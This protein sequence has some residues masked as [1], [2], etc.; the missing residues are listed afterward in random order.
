MIR[1]KAI[2]E[3]DIIKNIKGIQT[4]EQARLDGI[5]VEDKE[6]VTLCYSFGS[7]P[8]PG[9]DIK[10]FTNGKDKIACLKKDLLAAKHSIN[11][12][13]YIF[14]DDKIGKEVMSILC[15]K[16]SEGVDVRLIYDSIGSRHAP[17]RF[18]NKL[19]KA[20]GKVGEFFPPL[21]SYK[22]DEP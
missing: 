10:I 12:E 8:L 7:Y 17:R 16:A 2:S 18:F 3:R 4:L 6:L 11:I 9:N 22:I 15:K 21:F 13:Y 5:L 20:G 19:K 1:K 14:A